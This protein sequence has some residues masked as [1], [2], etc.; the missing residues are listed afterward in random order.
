MAMIETD[1]RNRLIAY[2]D[3]ELDKAQRTEIEKLAKKSRG[4]RRE[5]NALKKTFGFTRFDETPWFKPIVWELPR[6]N[7]VPLWRWAFASAALA[8]VIAAFGLFG[9]DSS[10]IKPKESWVMIAG[11]TLSMDQGYRLINMI[12]IEGDGH[13]E[14]KEPDIYTEIES[15]EKEQEEKLIFLLREKIVDLERS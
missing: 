11:D 1:L 2:L 12:M 5:L 8:T 7:R 6:V 4:C 15:L 13:Y 9:G 3:G 10:N 14:T